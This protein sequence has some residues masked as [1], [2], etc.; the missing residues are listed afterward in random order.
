LYGN[1]VDILDGLGITIIVSR[2]YEHL[3]CALSAHGSSLNSTWHSVPHPSGI[4]VNRKEGLLYVASTRNPNML[5]KFRVEAG[6]SAMMP[7][8]LLVFPGSTYMHDLA[9]IGNGLY[10][11]SAGHNCVVRFEKEDIER[12]W[13][14]ESIDSPL[15]PR[16]DKNYLQLNGIAGG[17]TLQESFFSASCEHPSSRRPGHKNF[18]VDGKGVIFSGK[19]RRVAARGLTRPHSVRFAENKSLFVLNSG[20]G[21]LCS[22]DLPRQ[23]YDVRASFPGWTRGLC[24]V[25]GYAFVG[26][27]HVLRRFANYAPGLNPNDCKCG[28]HIFD[29]GSGKIL[30]GV[31][32]PFGNQIFAIDWINSR[33]TGGF[34]MPQSF[35]RNAKR[36]CDL[37]A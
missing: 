26:T 36:A 24:F 10:A 21:Q 37:F 32:W 18:L 2:E 16:M 20:Y 6:T 27:S 25:G 17:E 4:A 28:V 3:L 19:T 11:N 15:G 8:S 35:R 9:F 33:C 29:M 23:G 30:G 7:K 14:P 22:V 34:M 12:V 13:W 5:V 1:F 31:I